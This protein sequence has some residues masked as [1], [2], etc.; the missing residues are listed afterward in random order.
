MFFKLTLHHGPLNFLSVDR[1]AHAEGGAEEAHGGVASELY[2][3]YPY[4]CPE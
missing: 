1:E 2:Y 4:P 3:S